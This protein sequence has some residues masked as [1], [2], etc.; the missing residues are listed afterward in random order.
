MPNP[1]DKIREHADAIM[2]ASE[3]N[4]RTAKAL[5]TEL[6][7]IVLEARAAGR[8]APWMRQREYKSWLMRV[9]EYAIR[10]VR[11]GSWARWDR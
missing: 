8:P 10:K 5:A 1:P 3:E 2:K 6:A 11:W 7:H 4:S 9:L